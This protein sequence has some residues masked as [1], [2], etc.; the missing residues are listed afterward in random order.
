MDNL[1]EDIPYQILALATEREGAI[2]QL[3]RDLPLDLVYEYGKGHGEIFRALCNFYNQT[4]VSPIDPS[5][6]KTWLKTETMIPDALG[7]D[8]QLD[9]YFKEAKAGDKATPQSVTALMRLY[10]NKAQRNEKIQE[11]S[12][13]SGD[14]NDFASTERVA[15]LLNQIESFNKSGSDPLDKVTTG[16]SIAED[17]EGLWELPDFFPTQFKSLN[18]ALGYTEQGGFCKGAVYGVL[19]QSG[20]GKSTFA[21]SLVNHWL[22]DGNKVLY[23]NYEEARAHWERVLFT[24]ITKQNIYKGE[25]LNDL[26]KKHYTRLFTDKVKE[27]GNNFMVRHDPDTVFF[28]DMESWVR[29]VANKGHNF[30]VLVIDT[31]QSMYVKELKNAPRWQQFEKMMVSLEKMAR[32]LDCVILITAQENANRMKEGREVVKQSDAG[33]ALTIIQKCTATIFITK[34]KMALGD[35]SMDDTIMQLQIP[36]NRIT[37]VASSEADAPLVRYNDATK[38]YENFDIPDG[39]GYESTMSDDFLTNPY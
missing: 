31:I 19:A 21:K 33:G 13:L 1:P 15:E 22:D 32:E 14:K 4:G 12:D 26:E 11:L 28:E 37:G 16:L 27:W 10:F 8:E 9:E 35:D 25:G 6:F 30:D 38:S 23:V 20:H 29:D 18:V 34:A 7:G 17:A 24:Q 5:A 2:E 36:K 39:Q 3:Q